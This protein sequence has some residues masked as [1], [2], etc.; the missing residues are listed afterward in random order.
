MRAFLVLLLLVIIGIA[1]GREVWPESH[2]DPDGH[3]R[4]HRGKLPADPGESALQI[5]QTN[6]HPHHRVLGGTT[7]TF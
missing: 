1:I 2:H 7:A 4:Y 6:P 3:T 5:R